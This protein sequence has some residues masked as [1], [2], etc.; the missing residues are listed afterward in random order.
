MDFL[1]M[2][3]YDLVCQ[4]LPPTIEDAHVEF[5]ASPSGIFIRLLAWSPTN[6]LKSADDTDPEPSLPSKIKT[7]VLEILE[8]YINRYAELFTLTNGV[9]A[10][11]QS[12]WTM[13]SSTSSASP[14]SSTSNPFTKQSTTPISDDG[15]VSQSLRFLA[16]AIRSNVWKSL[17]A[18]P[19]TISRIVQDVIIPNLVLRDYEIEQYEDDPMEWIRVDLFSLTASS[20]STGDG[21]SSIGE[22]STRRQASSDVLRAFVGVNLEVTTS[23]CS[24]WVGRGLDMYKADPRGEGVWKMKDCAVYLMTAVAARGVTSQVCALLHYS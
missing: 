14:S 23:I 21:A 15:L 20:S 4:D 19:E 12:V 3:F 22:G 8:F 1:T 16:T 6:L 18:S 10:Y 9:D 11:V 13:L 24:E 5:F 17:F 7:N 2:L